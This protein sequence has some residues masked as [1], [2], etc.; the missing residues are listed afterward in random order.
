MGQTH[1]KSCRVFHL[2]IQGL[3]IMIIVQ[4]SHVYALIMLIN[5]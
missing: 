5:A 3:A 1:A 2:Q 4:Q